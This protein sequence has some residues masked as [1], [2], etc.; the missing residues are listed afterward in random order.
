M[1]HNKILDIL[2]YYESTAEDVTGEYG[3][4][5]WFADNAIWNMRTLSFETEAETD[6]IFDSPIKPSKPT[7]AVHDYL[8]ELA[9]GDEAVKSDILQALAPLFMERKPVG[10]IWF[11][12]D[13][14][15][16]KSG[17][18]SALYRI[19]PRYLASVTLH[20]LEDGRDAPRLNGMLGNVVRESSEGHVEDSERYK[21]V[22]SH[23]DFEVHRFHS[24]ESVLVH[25]NVHTIFNANN[26]PTFTD[27]TKGVARRTYVVRFDNHFADNP[28]FEEE[29]FTPEF[30]GGLLTLILDMARQ[31][32]DNNYCYDWS[33]TTRRSKDDYEAE[34]NSVEAF[35]RDVTANTNVV[36]WTNYKTLGDN[37]SR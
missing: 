35:Y 5:V 27:K 4:K 6:A 11:V 10:V 22:G 23:E 12:G 21:S 14:A 17:L 3:H 8:L 34:S 18:V 20:A 26:I 9:N 2:H 37:Y 29:T 30:L 28:R 24:Q 15:N 33:T 31:I 25:G 1:T 7:Q 13:G 16:G 36:G 32:R 19:M